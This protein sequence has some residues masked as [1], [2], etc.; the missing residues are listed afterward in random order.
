[1]P[2]NR[3]FITKS[4]FMR[5]FIL[6]S[7]LLPALFLLSTAA[8][9]Q[10]A[11]RT[12]P[13]IESLVREVS[14]DSLRSYDRTLVAFGT[15][16]TLSSTTGSTGI[17]AARRWVL[18]CFQAYAAKSDGRM[19]AKMDTWIQ[20]ADSQRVNRPVFM[21]NVTATIKGGDPVDDRI[22]IVTAHLDSRNTNI[23]DS[24]GR[25][26]GANDDASGVSALLEMARIL[27][28]YPLKAT[29]M[30]VAVTG[31]EQGLL[32][33]GHLAREAKTHGWNVAAILNDDMIGQSTSSGTDLAA[34]T[35]V[36]VFSEAIPVAESPQDARL[37]KAL[38]GE[39]DS[40]SR[41]LARYMKMTA[42]AYVDNLSVQLIY[43]RDR[44]LRGGDHEP[45]QAED[46]TAVRITDYYENYNHQH[47]DIRVENGIQYGD[48]ERYVD[49]EYLRKNTCLN[50][51]TLASLASA[52][53]VPG[54]PKIDISRLSNDTRL[55][56]QVPRYGKAMGYY[57]LMR[58]TDEP[59]WQ[60]KFY[61]EK[62]E[63]T[64]P[65]SKDNY[66]FAVQAVGADGTMSVPVFPGIGR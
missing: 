64:L 30:L 39:N 36:R 13:H 19:I 52:P 20:P 35:R 32:G 45:F 17:G 66:F 34:N 44:F 49:F 23:M 21:G 53:S 25:S 4:A 14:P 10:E 15:R 24:T 12:N 16:H 40:R 26:P 7:V 58:E 47:Q 9:A 1:M 59:M 57:V 29:V 28:H 6:P 3:K 42:S 54:E 33:S 48:L 50:L 31:E 5:I 63:M 60:K 56:W 43:R 55:Y 27:S 51:A 37:R 22:F 18:K 8:I 62:M 38:G 41:E 65:Y 46:Y 61:T 2:G 11:I